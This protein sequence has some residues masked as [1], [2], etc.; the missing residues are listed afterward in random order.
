[1]KETI[2]AGM[3]V[4]FSEAIPPM[5]VLRVLFYWARVRY[6]AKHGG[7][8]YAWVRLEFLEEYEPHVL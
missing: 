8:R 7:Y 3:L 4:E 2:K 6:Q 1:M 5:E